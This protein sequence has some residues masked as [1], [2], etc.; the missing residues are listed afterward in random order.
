MKTRVRQLCDGRWV[1]ELEVKH[2][3]IIFWF[4]KRKRFVW[5]PIGDDTKGCSCGRQGCRGTFYEEPSD[6]HSID[7]TYHIIL[8]EEEANARELKFKAER[9]L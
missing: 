7:Y 9:G 8:T 3:K 2:D 4:I 6:V 1:A 5:T